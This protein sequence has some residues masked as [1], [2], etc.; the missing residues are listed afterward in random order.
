MLKN[1]ENFWNISPL[2]IYFHYLCFFLFK[3]ALNICKFTN[4]YVTLVVPVNGG[5]STWSAWSECSADCDGGTRTKTRTCT[6]PAPAYGGNGCGADNELTGTCNNQN[7]PGKLHFNCHTGLLLLCWI[8]FRRLQK[9]RGPLIFSILFFIRI[10]GNYKLN[11]KP[12]RSFG[13]SR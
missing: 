7:C 13:G 6:D 12:M 11:R 3:I 2:K 8:Y 4:L 9:K 5:L 1:I 10:F